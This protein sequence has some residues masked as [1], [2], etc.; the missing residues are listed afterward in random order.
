MGQRTWKQ[1]FYRRACEAWRR[2]QAALADGD[3]DA[4]RNFVAA[5]HME[6]G[7]S[8]GR[9]LPARELHRAAYPTRSARPEIIEPPPLPV[10]GTEIGLGESEVT[11]RPAVPPAPTK[12]DSELVDLYKET[13]LALAHGATPY[14]STA[15][16][17]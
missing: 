3:A 4:A 13:Q 15:R 1:R 16:S 5:L 9:P 17:R 14:R 11:P 10:V 12:T 6:L 2:L 8:A 7:I